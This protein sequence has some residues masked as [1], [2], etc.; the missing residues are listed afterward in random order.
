VAVVVLMVSTGVGA[1][2]AMVSSGPVAQPVLEAVQASGEVLREIDDPWSGTRWQLLSNAEHP[3][4]PRRLVLVELGRKAAAGLSAAEAAR[5]TLPRP[6]I[7]PGDQL[8]VE[9]HTPVVDASL[10][11]VAMGQATVGAWFDVRL[12]LGGQVLH[13]LALGPGRALLQA[14]PG[15]RS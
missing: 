1:Q 2:V 10:Q 4:A 11:A 12:K 6:V 5:P 8:I 13:V 3:E 9:E 7:H 15:G 14:G